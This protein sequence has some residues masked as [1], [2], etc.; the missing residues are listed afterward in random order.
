MDDIRRSGLI[1]GSLTPI[2]QGKM[3]KPKGTK[4]ERIPLPLPI[5]QHH[6]D[7]QF[8]IEFFFVNGYPFLAIETNKMNFI[9][10]EPCI[11]R[12]ISHITKT[13]DI[14]LDLYEAKRF[15]ITSIHEDNEFNIKTLKSHLLPIC[16]HIYSKESMLVS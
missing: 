12:T 11:L 3:T 4:I 7:L 2:L 1:Y 14:V 13:I 5:Y 16:T 8:Y 9:T 15:N 10:S 6:K